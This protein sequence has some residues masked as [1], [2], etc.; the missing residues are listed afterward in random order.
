MSLF[1]YLFGLICAQ[2]FFVPKINT[3][4]LINP[5]PTISFNNQD[6]NEVRILLAYLCIG[7][8]IAI[9]GCGLSYTGLK[10]LFTLTEYKIKH[11]ILAILGASIIIF[12]LHIALGNI[13]F[14]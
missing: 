2:C 12:G 7:V 13:A 10:R 4:S 1:I 5:N 9:Y 6:L 8:A 11:G 14:L 3:L